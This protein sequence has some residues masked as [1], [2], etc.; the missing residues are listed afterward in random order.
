MSQ[1]NFHPDCDSSR[2]QSVQDAVAWWHSGQPHLTVAT[3]GSTGEPKNIDLQ[4]KGID[5]SI[6]A[7]ANYAEGWFPEGRRGRTAIA[8]DMHHVGGLFALFRGLAW[9]WDMDVLPVK[10]HPDLQGTYDWLSLI[11]QQAMALTE[12][13]WQGLSVCLLGGGPLSA[14]ERDHLASQPCRIIQGYGMTETYTHIALKGLMDESYQCLPGLSVTTN[15]KGCLVIHCPDRGIHHL[16]T[17][18]LVELQGCGR[19]LWLGR[20]DDVILSAGKKVHPT[21]VEDR[22]QKHWPHRGFLVAVDHQQWGQAAVWL[23]EPLEDLDMQQWQKA[24]AHLPSWQRPKAL[25]QCVLPLTESGKWDRRKGRSMA[26][27]LAL[28]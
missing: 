28:L 19:F 8:L 14:L 11:P 6:A 2:Q 13:Q 20:A 25:V 21:A 17:T 12:D 18:D 26:Q 1:I 22:L 15:E 9:G 7:T 23:S 10:R 5:A 24:L 3:S 16:L 4:R 27:A